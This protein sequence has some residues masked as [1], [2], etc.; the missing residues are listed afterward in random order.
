M[1]TL[2]QVLSFII[3]IIFL[4][5]WIYWLKNMKSQNK[6]IEEIHAAVVI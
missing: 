4:V 5:L 2:L 6:L 3:S 1:S